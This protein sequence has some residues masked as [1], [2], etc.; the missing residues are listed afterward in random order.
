LI[1][2][3]LKARDAFTLRE[4]LLAWANAPF[5]MGYQS[6]TH[7][8]VMVIAFSYVITTPIICVMGALYFNIRY[9]VDK[10][11]L[12]CLFYIDFDSKGEIPKKAVRFVILSVFM[13]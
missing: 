7:L 8:N 11:N 13:F 2:N 5:D 9:F 4:E 6:A 1:V 3:K 12:L 10:Y